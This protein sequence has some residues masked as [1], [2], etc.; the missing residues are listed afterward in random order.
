MVPPVMVLPDLLRVNPV[1][2]ALVAHKWLVKKCPLPAIAVPV[3]NLRRV[4]FGFQMSIEIRV[5][6]PAATLALTIHV[7]FN[8]GP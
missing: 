4:L 6:I 2:V 8:G 7:V 5:G 1:A 3:I